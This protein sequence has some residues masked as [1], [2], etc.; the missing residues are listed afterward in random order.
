M[1]IPLP[2]DEV[3]AAPL[4][5]PL[6]PNQRR[7]LGVMIEKAKTTP[8]AYPITINAIVVGANQKNNRDPVT[9][10][11]DIDVER[12][13]EELAELKVVTESPLPS[14]AVKYMHHAYQWFKV[15]RAELAVMT[16]LLLRGE[17]TLGD[18][19]ARAARMEPI[20]DV[21]ALKAIVD[22]L[23]AR[24][25]MIE[26]TPPGRGQIVSHNLYREPELAALRARHGGR[27]SSAAHD[28]QGRDHPAGAERVSGEDRHATPTALAGAT[29]EQWAQLAS[30]VAELRAEVARLRDQVA[31]LEA[32]SAESAG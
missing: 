3:V 28:E 18:L 10:L 22:R 8:A 1:P 20:D 15:D 26:L 14:R 11:E 31:N 5:K 7:V 12:C 23:L 21:T 25:L 19:R 2:D 9:N 27:A 13:I 24:G 16:E 6:T 4:W 17:Q 32:K 30:E 29:A